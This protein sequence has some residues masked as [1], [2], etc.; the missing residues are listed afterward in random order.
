MTISMWI[1][2][3]RAQTT[4]VLKRPSTGNPSGVHG[5]ARDCAVS[6][7]D[8]FESVEFLEELSQ[9]SLGIITVDPG[10]TLLLMPGREIAT[11]PRSLKPES[12]NPATKQGP[13]PMPQ[14]VH[15]PFPQ[16][17]FQSNTPKAISKSQHF[18]VPKPAPSFK[19]LKS[20]SE[21]RESLRSHCRSGCAS[22]RSCWNSCC[23]SDCAFAMSKIQA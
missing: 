7:R 14:V 19:T 16:P 12:Q 23:C 8:S 18:Q 21:T 2:A 9:A 11:I 20:Q 1:M 10:P 3:N 15:E 22:C 4:G 5:M 6:H 13:R 17:H